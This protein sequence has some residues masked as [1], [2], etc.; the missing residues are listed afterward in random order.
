ML[1]QAYFVLFKVNR[2]L[3]L[4]I[5]RIINGF[6]SFNSSVWLAS[7]VDMLL[8]LHLHALDFAEVSSNSD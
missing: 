4:S 3:K 8:I 6:K 5:F 1:F 7:K 2:K